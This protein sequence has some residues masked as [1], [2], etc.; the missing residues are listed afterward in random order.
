MTGL[1]GFRFE[2]ERGAQREAVFF[3][4]YKL[5]RTNYDYTVQL[6]GDI[7]GRV[8]Y[9][10]A[11][12][13]QKNQ[14]Y[15]T[16]AD[17]RVGLTYYPIRPGAGLFHGTKLNFNF[18]KGVQEPNLFAQFDSLYGQLVQNGE[19]SIAQQFGIHPIGAQRSR[20]YDGGVEQSLFSQRVVARATYFHNEFGNQVEFVSAGSLASIGVSPQVQAII[21]DSL[22]GADVNTLA[23]RAQGLESSVEYGIGHD[24]FVRAGYTYLDAVVQH[25]FS[26]DAVAPSMNPNLPG[27]RDR[28]QFSACAGRGRFAGLRIPGSRPCLTTTNVGQ[29]R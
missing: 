27:V 11:G 25:S 7:K 8:F 15:G 20:S 16:E 5:E 23:F 22:G 19:A 3:E 29:R 4:D 13:L 10:L 2:N 26:S 28:R 1:F 14:L 24:I 17:P 12:G 6:S 9:T 18:A 21:N